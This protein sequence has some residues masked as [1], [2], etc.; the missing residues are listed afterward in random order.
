ML[1]ALLQGTVDLPAQHVLKAYYF[2]FFGALVCLF[3]YFNVYFQYKGFSEHQIGV[4]STVRPWVAAVAGGHRQ[5]S[6]AAYRLHHHALV[7]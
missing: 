6:T 1:K 7:Q 3:P 2:T 5:H 4:L